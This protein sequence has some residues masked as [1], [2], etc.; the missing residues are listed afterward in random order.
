M[1][2]QTFFGKGKD[3]RAV[4]DLGKR[5]LAI[6]ALMIAAIVWIGLYP[7]PVIDTAKGSLEKARHEAG[8]VTSVAGPLPQGAD[9]DRR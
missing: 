3:E 2:Q 8:V 4:P 7:Q 6:M 5:E 1:I 9:N